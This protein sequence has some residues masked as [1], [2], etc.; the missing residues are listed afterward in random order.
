M[1]STRIASAFTN[2]PATIAEGPRPVKAP[3]SHRNRIR[4]PQKDP[5][6]RFALVTDLL[7]Y[8]PVRHVGPRA[9][10][11]DALDSGLRFWRLH[12]PKGLR[13]SSTY[14][15]CGIACVAAFS[16]SRPI[17]CAPFRKDLNWIPDGVILAPVA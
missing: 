9:E 17:V 3:F 11:A 16:G 4:F 12:R 1:P 8:K 15:Y 13:A 6:L 14:Y 7:A 10:L 2:M 5:E